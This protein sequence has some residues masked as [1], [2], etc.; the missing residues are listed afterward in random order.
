MPPPGLELPLELAA[1][2]ILTFHYSNQGAEARQL[3]LPDEDAVKASGNFFAVFDGVTLEHQSPYPNPSPAALAAQVAVDTSYEAYQSASQKSEALVLE[4]FRKANKRVEEYNQ[5]LGIT[6][7][8]VNYLDKQYAAAVGALG[9]IEGG[10]LFYGQINDCGVAV[11]DNQL[12]QV[13]SS[14]IAGGYE[15]WLVEMREKQGYAPDS[16]EE[17]QY[18]RRNLVNKTV[19][20]A[21]GQ[22]LAFGVLTGEPEANQFVRTGNVQVRPGWTVVC[23]SDGFIPHLEDN[24]VIQ[25]L[26]EAPRQEIEAYL[27]TF[28]SYPYTKERSMIVVRV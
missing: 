9:F 12:R 19:R 26:A 10:R 5:S 11:Y 24:K 16:Q 22:E 6:P 7:A 21:G 28:R 2:E 14:I 17:H 27:R 18:V 4:A 23:Y 25:K 3:R 8:T 1:V 20:L 15:A 13:A